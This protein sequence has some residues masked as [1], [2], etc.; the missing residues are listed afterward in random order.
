MAKTRVSR[1]L[2]IYTASYLYALYVFLSPSPPKSLHVAQL[3]LMG[4]RGNK[5]SRRVPMSSIG[6]P[7]R[8]TE[9][10]SGDRYGSVE[11]MRDDV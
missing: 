3:S 5:K 9:G 6:N 4:S 1:P 10:G 8:L 2:R 11:Q 7:A